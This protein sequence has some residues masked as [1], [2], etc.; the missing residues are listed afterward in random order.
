MAKISV[1]IPVYNVEPYLDRCIESVVNQTY[2][3]LEIILVDDGSP[4]HC[5]AICDRWAERDSRIIVIHQ[6]NGGLSAAR[7]TGIERASGAYLA[8]VDSDD[9]ISEDM[10]AAMI[11]GLERT[12]SGMATCGTWVIENGKVTT[13]HDPKTELVLGTI[14]AMDELLR[15][16]LIGEAAC[17]KIYRREVFDGIRFPVG[18]INEDIVVMP[19]LIEHARQIFYTGKSYYYYDRGNLGSITHAEY[20]EKRSIYIKHIR[21]TNSYIR[22]AYP[23]LR[24]ALTAFNIRYCVNPYRRFA[25][26]PALQKAFREDYAF[27]RSET[28]KIT[29]AYLCS[30][31]IS[32]KRKLTLLCCLLGIYRPLRSIKRQLLT[33]K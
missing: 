10:Y 24:A 22:L 16:G 12:S 7:N 25:E 18:E 4:D 28:I 6:A 30:R 17:N 26:N 14:Q 31:H 29:P 15:A 21:D 5:P 20:D 3:D 13:K 2:R 19:R 9:Y 1:V 32:L 8:F 33:K 27:Y 23:Q 11:E